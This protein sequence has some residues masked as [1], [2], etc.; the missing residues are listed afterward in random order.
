MD[1]KDL[2]ENKISETNQTE[3]NEKI[4]LDQIRALADR[5]EFT[6]ARDMLD[7]Y[8]D[9]QIEDPDIIR[10]CV[11]LINTIDLRRARSLLSDAEKLID[12]KKYKLAYRSVELAGKLTPDNAGIAKDC[13]LCFKKIETI[14]RTVVSRAK[15]K[16]NKNDAQGAVKYLT[17]A[18]NN[19]INS[20]E[21][22]SEIDELLDSLKEK[23]ESEN[24][25]EGEIS[26]EGAGP[27]AAENVLLTEEVN[28]TDYNEEDTSAQ[29]GKT[30]RKLSKKAVISAVVLFLLLVAV[31]Y[32]YSPSHVDLRNQLFAFI[33]GNSSADTSGTVMSAGLSKQGG[34]VLPDGRRNPSSQGE[35]PLGGDGSFEGE[36]GPGGAAEGARGENPAEG[37][38]ATGQGEGSDTGEG[39]ENGMTAEQE[40]IPSDRM[41]GDPARYSRT[42][43]NAVEDESSLES[44]TPVDAPTP[45][46]QSEDTDAM[47][48]RGDQAKSG[49]GGEPDYELAL[50]WYQRAAERGNPTA[51]RLYE[52]TLSYMSLSMEDGTTMSPAVQKSRIAAYTGLSESRL[53]FLETA[54]ITDGREGSLFDCYD[55]N[56]NMLREKMVLMSDGSIQGYYIDEGRLFS[57]EGYFR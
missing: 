51:Q 15:E 25:D 3:E 22:S 10:E 41:Q 1:E 53:H 44:T 5:N 55:A 14:A 52:E 19:F 11:E 32:G 27:E 9:Q 2:K 12:E 54:I 36:R 8:M 46:P 45:P 57:A 18:K 49:E 33:K 26:A 17:Y 39:I 43:V 28:N 24:T 34:D 50:Q 30:R 38:D 4:G 47:V 23:Q 13:G 16:I 35:R 31:Y 20:E 21:L 40:N 56:G 37:G 29:T 48:L 7:K 6:K 42:D